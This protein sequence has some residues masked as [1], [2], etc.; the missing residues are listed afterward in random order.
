MST[1]PATPD[2]IDRP[3]DVSRRCRL[4]VIASAGT[5]SRL[6]AAGPQSANEAFGTIVRAGDIA[7]ILLSPRG[8]ADGGIMEES[9]FQRLAEPLVAPLQ[10]HG[11]AVMVEEHSR[12]A[13]RTGADGVQL[14]QDPDA[15]S[16]AMDRLSRQMMVAAGNVRSRH[17]AL[18]L[19]EL[20]PDYVMFGRPGGDIREEPHPKNLDLARWWAAM[21]EIPC[22]VLGGSHVESALAVAATGAEFVAL[23]AALFGPAGSEDQANA[24]PAT[25][26]PDPSVIEALAR[27]AAEAVARVNALLDAE[28]PRFE[29]AA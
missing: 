15:L 18:V 29:D 22:V 13:G 12:V 27:R 19:G 6:G 1:A 14:G 17:T 5:L 21:V 10:A 4:V 23:E 7:S 26:S 3:Q 25:M 11:V 2:A 8:A 9:A 20:Q 28:A 16:D 24:G